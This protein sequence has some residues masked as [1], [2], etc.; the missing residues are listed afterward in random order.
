[1]MTNKELKFHNSWRVTLET[2]APTINGKRMIWGT[3]PYK[4]WLESIKQIDPMI[5][6]AMDTDFGDDEESA[7]TA[8]QKLNTQFPYIWKLSNEKW[9]YI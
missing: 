8:M 6:E 4:Q 3:K 2:K 7:R 9:A 1:M 5:R